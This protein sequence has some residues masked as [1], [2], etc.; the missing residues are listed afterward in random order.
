MKYTF[1][2]MVFVH[3]SWNLNLELEFGTE[4]LESDAMKAGY[5]RSTK[6]VKW[7]QMVEPYSKSDVFN[8]YS[9]PSPLCVMISKIYYVQV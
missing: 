5:L 1:I 3:M 2:N 6:R 9:K 8:C 4:T 7:H